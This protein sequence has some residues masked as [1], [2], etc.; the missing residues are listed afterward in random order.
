MNHLV[1]SLWVLAL[2]TAY[3]SVVDFGINLDRSPSRWKLAFL[4]EN[5]CGQ[6]VVNLIRGRS[7][8]IARNKDDY[9]VIWIECECKSI[10]WNAT[11]VQNKSVF[12]FIKNKPAISVVVLDGCEG[13]VQRFLRQQL[14]RVERLT[15]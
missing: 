7:I 12:G 8:K 5:H 9:P 11:T 1:R 3:I 4:S 15:P 2:I 10:A 13:R 6:V 14:L